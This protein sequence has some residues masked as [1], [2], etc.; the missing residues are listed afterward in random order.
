MKL[1]KWLAFFVLTLSL[2]LTLCACDGEDGTTEAPGATTPPAEQQ[3]PS[4]AECEHQ[5]GEWVVTKEPTCNVKGFQIRSCTLCEKSETESIDA[6]GHDKADHAAKAPTCTEVGWDAYVACSRCDYTTYQQKDE[7]GHLYENYEC[8]RCDLPYTSQG[9]NFVS[10][11]DGTCYVRGMGS[12]RDTKIFVPSTS[13]DGDTVTGIGADAF[14]GCKT[15]E[16]IVLS[17]SITSI[18]SMAFCACNNLTDITIPEGVTSIGYAAFADCASLRDIVLPA[19]VTS[20]ENFVFHQCANIES[21]TVDPSNSVY[22]SDGNCLIQTESKS[23]IAGCKNSVIPAD[24]SVERIA[25]GVFDGCTELKT[26]VIPKQVW[27]IGWGAFNN[28][29]N[30]DTIYY[31]GSTDDWDSMVIL[32]EN[33]S[34]TNATVYFY[35]PKRAPDADGNY[36]RYV[37]GVPTPW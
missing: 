19:S 17:E 24:G 12:C 15:I 4:P 16:G 28:C 21:I 14:S 27:N 26:I 37:D 18:G 31:G 25:N 32:E 33:A 29:A 34:L 6:L 30:L 5:Y 2:L 1:F 10:N 20:I 22:H 7:L 13:P 11:G 3:N 23:L 36:W 35:A 9:L 8:T